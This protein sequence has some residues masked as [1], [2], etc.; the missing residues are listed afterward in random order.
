VRGVKVRGDYQQY[1]LGPDGAV[2][3]CGE[4]MA[5]KLAALRSTG[6]APD[7]V[8][9]K[10]VLDVGTDM[11][12]WAFLASTAGARS[13]LGLD[14]NRDVKTVV[15]HVDLVAQNT[16][17]A[18]R[19]PRHDRVRFK[20]VNLGRQWHEYGLFDVAFAM[21]VTHHI[22]AQ[23]GDHASVWFWLARHVIPSGLLVWEGPLSDSDP[24]I[25]K[26][27]P[28]ALQSGW[29]WKAL[30]EAAALYFSTE[31]IGPARHEATRELWLL[32]RK[33][34][35][36]GACIGHYL[37]VKGAG[38]ASEAFGRDGGRRIKEIEDALGVK[39][40]PGSLNL[41]GVGFDWE[42]DYYRVQILDSTDRRNPDAPWAPRWCRFY[43]ASV[44]NVGGWAMRFESED[45]PE[46]FVEIVSPHQ[47]R[48]L[49]PE[50]G[51]GV[52]LP[53]VRTM[54][55]FSRL[56]EASGAPIR[57]AEIGVFM[58]WMSKF[59]LHRPDIHLTMVD[60][61]EADGSS[62][63]DGTGDFH[64]ELSAEQQSRCMESALDATEFAADRRTVLRKRSVDAAREVADGSLDFVFIDGDHSYEGVRADIAAWR[65]KVKPGG[66]LG[67][68]D[69]A[70][71]KFPGVADAVDE[72]AIL[73]GLKL[74]LAEDRT[75]FVRVPTC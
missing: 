31:Y 67:G 37:A 62:Y 41:T 17:I 71:P 42:R 27:I 21:S 48:A 9:G 38:G 5:A 52:M 47:L 70:S 43:P 44:G 60:P 2:T 53:W 63:A 55:L 72:F 54:A 23:C 58:G 25:R 61:W 4:R 35:P 40:Y 7:F 66:L 8:A 57:G 11:G 73:E 69:Y 29:N 59:L 32:R 68:H 10:S 30:S 24:V 19:Y 34:G 3:W 28:P 12:F 46:D 65:G 22:Y 56:P 15:G 74:D 50:V 14:R 45:Y 16:E 39:P 18:Q 51:G 1:D 64:A 33:E 6:L 49:V 75:W 20:P 26:D 13:V 36:T